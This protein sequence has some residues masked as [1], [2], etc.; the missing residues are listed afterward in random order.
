MIDAQGAD[1]PVWQSNYSLLRE[2]CSLNRSVRRT[3]KSAW[4]RWISLPVHN[5]K[6]NTFPQRSG[7]ATYMKEKFYMKETWVF[8]SLWG[9]RRMLQVCRSGGPHSAWRTPSAAC[10]GSSAQCGSAPATGTGKPVFSADSTRRAELR[11]F[12]TELNPQCQGRE[13]G[14]DKHFYC[15]MGFITKKRSKEVDDLGVV[16]MT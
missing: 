6:P 10:T 5:S 2:S 8:W 9:G 12:S 4:G 13:N 16:R 14:M 7:M 1:V 15:Q 11:G 3:R